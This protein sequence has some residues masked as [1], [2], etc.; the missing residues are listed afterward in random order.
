MQTSLCEALPPAPWVAFPPP[1]HVDVDHP[2][3]V[4]A[5]G[6]PLQDSFVK[7]LVLVPH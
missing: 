3:E 2:M 7:D 4:S 1:P 5:S 6:L